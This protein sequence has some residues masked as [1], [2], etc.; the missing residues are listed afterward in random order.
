VGY[1][2]GAG[3]HSFG[4]AANDEFPMTLNGIE[5]DLHD[6]YP[7]GSLEDGDV[8]SVGSIRVA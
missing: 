3:P 4:G 1:G 6:H 2:L 7:D 8:S 5:I